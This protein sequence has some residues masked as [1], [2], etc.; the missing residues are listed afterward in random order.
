MRHHDD[1]DTQINLTPMLD[2]VFIML[3]FFIVTATFVKEV[4]LD[5]NA[6]EPTAHPP[7]EH[8]MKH[9]VVRI[10]ADNRIN[11][12]DRAID[13]RAVDK[14]L[15]RLH[16]QAPKAD[17]VI[18]AHAQSNTNTLTRVIDAARAVGIVRIS[19]ADRSKRA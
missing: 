2:I 13:V 15:A 18:D 1:S 7:P 3:I 5:I 10:A 11:I 19:L 14:H 4:G 6:P 17:V 9:I 16:A 12:A 8:L